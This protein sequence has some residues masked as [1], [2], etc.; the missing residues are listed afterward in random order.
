MSART[1]TVASLTTSGPLSGNSQ[2]QEEGDTDFS[3]YAVVSLVLPVF[4]LM[5]LDMNPLQLA[6]TQCGVG[7]VCVHIELLS[8]YFNLPQLSVV[9]VQC[10]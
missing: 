6:S 9:L 7:P 8:T 10:M 1:D 4:V 3:T 2:E 5:T